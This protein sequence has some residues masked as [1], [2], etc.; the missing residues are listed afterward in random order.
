M[1]AFVEGV[2]NLHLQFNFSKPIIFHSLFFSCFK[3]ELKAIVLPCCPDNDSV[4]HKYLAEMRRLD[5]DET[6]FISFVQL[7]ST[8]LAW[9]PD[10]GN[11]IILHTH[12][13]DSSDH[14]ETSY[15]PTNLVIFLSFILVGPPFLTYT[16]FNY[17]L[18]DPKEKHLEGLYIGFYIL[19]NNIPSSTLS[20][21]WANAP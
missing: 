14:D 6:S 8:T 15:P 21:S 9:W 19:P 5:H 13:H 1:G 18:G 7:R 4:T 11:S 3:D 12:D 2:W 16:H 10:D 17:F 20:P